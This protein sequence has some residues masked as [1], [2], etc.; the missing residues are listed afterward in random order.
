MTLRD[1]ARKLQATVDALTLRERLLLFAGA[2]VIAVALWEALLA[3]PL[4]A[5]EARASQQLTQ[6]TDRLAKLDEAMSLAAA[7]IGDGL[8]G[9]LERRQ[10]L[11]HQLEA[12]QEQVR[13]FT[14]DLVDPEQMR[15]VLEQLI[16]RQKGLTLIR[17]SNLEVEPLL[18]QGD[19]DETAG[20]DQP[21]LYRHGLELVVDGSY[22]DCLKYL[23]AVERLP[24][25][26]YW[27]GLS[28]TAKEYPQ[29]EITLELF[30]LSLDK[31][32]IGV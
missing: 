14:S 3:G 27:G 12:N 25:H 32:W 23:E 11:E 29:N 19:E 24:W 6:A 10:A 8:S 17:A 28:L 5:R 1:R 9:Q 30:T 31:E 20:D 4:E 22:L 26:L 16:D 15:H 7:G 21:M 13:V 18:E 2:L